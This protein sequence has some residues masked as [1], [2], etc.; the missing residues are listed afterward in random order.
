MARMFHHLIGCR[1]LL[2]VGVTATG[3][4]SGCLPL[5]PPRVDY[6]PPPPLHC[7]AL[8]PCEQPDAD[9]PKPAVSPSGAAECL[10]LPANPELIDLPTA[11]QLADRQNPEIAVARERIREALAIQDRAEVLWLPQLDYGPTWMRHDGQIQR[12]SGE[13]IT[14]SRSSLFVGGA[15]NFNWDLGELLY[16]PLVAQ[17]FTAAR[18]AGA[19]ATAHERLLDV[20]VTYFD[21]LQTY[22]SIEVNRET[23]ANARHLLELTENYEK[24]GKGAAADTARARVEA[25]LRETEQLELEGRVIVI[26]ARLAQLVQLP[27]ETVF[28]PLE[29]ALVPLAVVP[30]EA[31]LTE[32]IAQAAAYRPE[33]AESRALILAAVERWRAAKVAPLVPRLQFAVSGGGFGGGPN[34]FFGDFDGRSDVSVSAVWR[35]NQLGLG[36]AAVSRERESQYAQAIFRRHSVEAAVAAQVVQNFGVAFSRRREL[37]SAQRSVAAARDSYRLNEERVRR[38][39]EQG[40][41]IELLQAIQALARARQDYVQIIADYNRAQFR[42]YTSLGN[43]PLCALET[44]KAIPIKEPAIPEKAPAAEAAPPPKPLNDGQE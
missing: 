33:L 24:A 18:Q 3:C 25:N 44:T 36:D 23:L 9:S 2:W 6:P 22:A 41:P 5:C 35:L 28:R 13:V 1:R 21:L 12:S 34:S 14:V 38:A 11:L 8:A 16:A 20:A 27:P 19:A 26:S 10:L 30:E 7:P 31:P 32:L 17:Q 4:L 39:P 42:L 43:P 29:P 15:V 37:D 40:R